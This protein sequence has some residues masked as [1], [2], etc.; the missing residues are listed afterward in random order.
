M[1]AT[2]DYDPENDILRVEIAKAKKSKTRKFEDWLTEKRDAETGDL[3]AVE[4]NGFVNVLSEI[5]LERTLHGHRDKVYPPVLVR[6]ADA[7]MVE[8]SRDGLKDLKDILRQYALTPEKERL[9]PARVMMEFLEHMI[10]PKV[11][12]KKK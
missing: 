9:A 1:G 12:R 2:A 5:E 3:L 6:L 11:S 10:I 4:I 8:Y 7:L